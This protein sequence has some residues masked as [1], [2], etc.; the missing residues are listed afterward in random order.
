MGTQFDD[1][2][3]LLF[4]VLEGIR[5]W[6]STLERTIRDL[7]KHAQIEKR[8]KAS[9]SANHQQLTK[10]HKGRLVSIGVIS[11]SLLFSA[12]FGVT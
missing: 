6:N 8:G 9:D 4:I 10:V 2:C 5:I 11:K 12:F 1:W 3:V 7:E